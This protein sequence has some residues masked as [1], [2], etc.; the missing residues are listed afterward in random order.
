[1][2]KK[3]TLAMSII[4]S[5]IVFTA[6]VKAQQTNCSFCTC[7]KPASTF[8]HHQECFAI[9]PNQGSPSIPTYGYYSVDSCES[10]CKGHYKASSICDWGAFP[11]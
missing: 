6:P 4:A 5:G 1:M 3:T 10:Y 11:C 8:P 2:L 9:P 7:V